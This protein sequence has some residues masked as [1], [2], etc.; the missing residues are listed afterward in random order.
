MLMLSEKS[1]DPASVCKID[2]RR[3]R[4][5]PVARR[6]QSKTRP[7][8]RDSWQR[9]NAD[10]LKK[11][12]NAARLRVNTSDVFTF[13]FRAAGFCILADCCG[14]FSSALYPIFVPQDAFRNQPQRSA[15]IRPLW[16]HREDRP[17]RLQP[18]GV[19][20]KL[21]LW[22]KCAMLC[23]FS[24]FF[25]SLLFSLLVPAD[26]WALREQ[27]TIFIFLFIFYKTPATPV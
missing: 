8:N 10:G 12:K 19:R 17:R 11:K 23:I 15:S 24:L 18:C 21:F 25:L 1:T 6:F 26:F 14:F 7:E 4:A 2:S 3:W 27:E 9:L 20:G 22:E 16:S 13:P 5:G